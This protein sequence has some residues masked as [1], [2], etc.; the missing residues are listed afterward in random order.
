[1]A[2]GRR[3]QDV[4]LLRFRALTYQ[5]RPEEFPLPDRAAAP[6]R[7]QPLLS[8]RFATQAAQ[9][10]ASFQPEPRNRWRLTL[11]LPPQGRQTLSKACLASSKGLILSQAPSPAPP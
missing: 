9:G 7:S 2:M 10:V 5:T 11:K 3:G 1:M 6:S 8:K 4:P